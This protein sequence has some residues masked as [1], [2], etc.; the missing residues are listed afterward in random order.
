MIW[1]MQYALTIDVRVLRTA[2]R[3]QRRRRLIPIVAQLLLMLPAV[4]CAIV[5]PPFAPPGDVRGLATGGLAV[6]GGIAG[7]GFH[8]SRIAWAL[9]QAPLAPASA[10]VASH[11]LALHRTLHDPDLAGI[12]R[13]TEAVGLLY[14]LA[15]AA[16]RLARD[17]GDTIPGLAAADLATTAARDADTTR[18]ELLDGVRRLLDTIAS[19]QRVIRDPVADHQSPSPPPPE[20]GPRESVDRT[21]DGLDHAGRSA[22][23]LVTLALTTLA[24][25]RPPYRR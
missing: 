7:L 25:N 20:P 9:D 2:R 1:D 15:H 3:Y 21:A 13:H 6:L 8:S 5:W 10:R 24:P 22:L 14:L 18:A 12:E 19:V 11:A 16:R 17:L 4:A 23:D